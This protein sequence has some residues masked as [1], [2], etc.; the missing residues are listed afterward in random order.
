MGFKITSSHH[1]YLIPKEPSVIIKAY[2]IEGIPFDFDYLDDIESINE[3]NPEVL[4]EANRN[5]GIHADDMFRKSDYLIAEMLHP[6]LFDLEIDNPEE[7]P[8]VNKN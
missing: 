7:L 6:L 1:W 3:T 4:A 5:K 2:F 8:Q